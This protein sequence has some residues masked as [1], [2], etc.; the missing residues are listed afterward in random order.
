MSDLDYAF[1]EFVETTRIL[2]AIIDKHWQFEEYKIIINCLEKIINV[3]KE[4]KK[5]FDLCVK[6]GVNYFG[7]D[8]SINFD[9]DKIISVKASY[10]STYI[11]SF[12][13]KENS[14]FFFISY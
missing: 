8:S 2:N 10:T 11:F 9:V 1:R 7:S 14:S 13:R 12:K 6:H 3:K 4:K 5:L